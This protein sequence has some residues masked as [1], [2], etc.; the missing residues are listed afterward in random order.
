MKNLEHSIAAINH[1]GFSAAFKSA[2]RNKRDGEPTFGAVRKQAV[3][4]QRLRSTIREEARPG[5]YFSTEREPMTDQRR[6]AIALRHVAFEDLG[7]LSAVLEAA[8][9]TIS[10]NDAAIDDL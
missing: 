7:L 8:G 5:P 3:V 1:C 6:S 4:D 10:L 9:W 2:S